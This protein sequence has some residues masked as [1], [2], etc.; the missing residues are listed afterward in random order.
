MW[1]HAC[2]LVYKTRKIS[3]E[4]YRVMTGDDPLRL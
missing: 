4:A 1:A 2:K 3:S